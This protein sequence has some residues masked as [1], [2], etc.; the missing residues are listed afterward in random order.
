MSRTALYRLVIALTLVAMAWPGT[1]GAAKERSKTVPVSGSLTGAAE[2]PFDS[3]LCDA[4]AGEYRASP[5]D[6]AYSGT[7]KLVGTFNGTGKFCGHNTRSL[8]RPGSVATIEIILFTGTVK[9]CG[10]GT[11]KYEVRGFVTPSPGPGRLATAD[12]FWK[13]I[14]GSGTGGLRSLTS[15]GGRNAGQMNSDTSLATDF[16][17]S[18]SC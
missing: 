16:K 7:A 8:A 2:P 3:S 10:T 1:A 4:Q 15:G 11:V 13:I 5:G 12:E 18:V 14:P 6:F 9:G 17:G